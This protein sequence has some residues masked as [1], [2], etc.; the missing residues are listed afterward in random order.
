MQTE[1]SVGML[2]KAFK[3]NWW[4]IVLIVLAVTVLVAAYT[5][6]FVAKKYSSN[7]KFYIVNR[8]YRYDYTSSSLLSATAYLANDYIDI[9]CSDEVLIPVVTQLNEKYGINYTKNQVLSMITSQTRDNSSIFT[10]TVTSS[11]AEHSWRI[12]ELISVIAPDAVAAV[13]RPSTQ[14]TEE[15]EASSA[16]QTSVCIKSLTAPQQASSYDS[17]NLMRSCVLAVI[18]SFI[19]SYVLFLVLK[20]LDTIIRTED[21]IKA[22]TDRPILATIPSWGAKSKKTRES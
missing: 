16:D 18:I 14:G 1:I 17:P 7:V 3:D 19:L 12:A 5:N 6:F 22:L 15:S 9:I 13:A 11:N 4:K 8:D 20:L 10:I 2:W 21:N